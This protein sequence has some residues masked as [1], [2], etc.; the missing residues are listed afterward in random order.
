VYEGVPDLTAWRS[1][2]ANEIASE[3][4]DVGGAA[5]SYEDALKRLAARFWVKRDCV[6]TGLTA[7]DAQIGGFFEGDLTVIA[8][9]PGMGKTS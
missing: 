5:M 3:G 2:L 6:L 9:R 8:A 1:T 7:L 4:V